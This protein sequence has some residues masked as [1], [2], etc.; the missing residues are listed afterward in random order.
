M[1]SID[2][3]IAIYKAELRA[4]DKWLCTIKKTYNCTKERPLKPMEMLDN[5]DYNKIM[6]W[7]EKIRTMEQLLG[8]SKEEVAKYEDEIFTKD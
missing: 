2:E 8:L 5:T 4:Y 1:K 6:I 3:M 7:N